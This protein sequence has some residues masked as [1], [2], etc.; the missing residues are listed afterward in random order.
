MKNKNSFLYFP[1]LS[2]QKTFSALEVGVVH[3]VGL[4]AQFRDRVTLG[5]CGTS[6]GL[7]VS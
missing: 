5:K 6:W 4:S 3:A 1:P 7:C 2:H